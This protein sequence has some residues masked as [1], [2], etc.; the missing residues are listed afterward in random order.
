M[1][2]KKF[3]IQLLLLLIFIT[4]QNVS[5]FIFLSHKNAFILIIKLGDYF[6]ATQKLIN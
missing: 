1:S 6:F 3:I 5:Q 2:Q 4:E